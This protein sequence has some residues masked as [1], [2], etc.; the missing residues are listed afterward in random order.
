MR[1]FVIESL[2]PIESKKDLGYEARE[3]GSVSAAIETMNGSKIRDTLA[4]MTAAMNEIERQE[5]AAESIPNL[6]REALER[7]F[8][9]AAKS[10]TKEEFQSSLSRLEEEVEEVERKRRMEEKEMAER[11]RGMASATEKGEREVFAGGE[12][13][14]K[15][16][17]NAVWLAE[18]SAKNAVESQALEAAQMEAADTRLAASVMREESAAMRAEMQ[19]VTE[20]RESFL[21]CAKS[22]KSE[23]RAFQEETTAFQAQVALYK[24]ESAS[25][26]E[27]VQEYYRVKTAVYKESEER[28]RQQLSAASCGRPDCVAEA[29]ET[30]RR[31]RE[32]TSELAEVRKE[33]LEA[34]ARHVVATAESTVSKMEAMMKN[35]TSLREEKRVMMTKKSSK[36][37]KMMKKEMEGRSIHQ[38]AKQVK[39]MAME[40]FSASSAKEATGS[41]VR[42]SALTK[43]ANTSPA[44]VRRSSSSN[45]I[46]FSGGATIG[47]NRTDMYHRKSRD[48]LW[49]NRDSSSVMKQNAKEMQQESQT[50]TVQSQVQQE[51][52]MQMMQQESQMQMMQSEMRKESQMM[53]SEVH[54]ESQRM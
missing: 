48:A 22:F 30:Q 51:S 53:Q 45:S 2:T 46:D 20:S 10:M 24:E 36:A 14:E 21:R 9:R 41:G 47:I 8:D 35:E 27:S 1:N 38:E 49:E 3:R 50:Q 52:Q 15:G 39:S 29:E 6:G 37:E 44:T 16:Q 43:K 13:A 40:S 28:L 31:V 5:F 7:I 42:N 33:L 11:N 17:R 19:S 12:K 25:F 32:L 18:K 34:S 54:E 23:C 4:E 26:R